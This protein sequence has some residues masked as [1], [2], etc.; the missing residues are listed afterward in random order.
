M[1]YENFTKHITLQWQVVIEGWLLPK[2]ASPSTLVTK[3][4][5]EILYNAFKTGTTKFC[6][7]SDA[8]WASWDATHFQGLLSMHMNEGMDEGQSDSGVDIGL[9]SMTSSA[10][11]LH[12]VPLSAGPSLM[13][14]TPITAPAN[15]FTTNPPSS[16]FDLAPSPSPL[17][18]TPVVKKVCKPHSDKGKVSKENK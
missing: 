16:L 12:T 2:F 4:E 15:T 8:E 10:M 9:L 17:V 3:T 11:T 6:C 5:V 1:Y 14:Q 18:N 13:S 7:M